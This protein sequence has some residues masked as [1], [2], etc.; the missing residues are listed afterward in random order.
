MNFV[1]EF[2]SKMGTFFYT[3]A[4]IIALPFWIVWVMWRKDL[5]FFGALAYIDIQMQRELVK[6]QKIRAELE[7]KRKAQRK[8]IKRLLDVQAKKV[9]NKVNEELLDKG[10]HVDITVKDEE[11]NDGNIKG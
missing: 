10:I 4:F 5:N 9:E 6:L 3:I 1:E 8:E 11:K 2:V 7:E